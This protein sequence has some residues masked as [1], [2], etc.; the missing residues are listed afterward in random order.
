[1]IPKNVINK[2]DVLVA[3]TLMSVEGDK[4]NSTKFDALFELNGEKFRLAP[5]K[6][7][8]KAFEVAGSSLHVSLF[9]G[10]AESNRF[11]NSLGIRVVSKD[12]AIS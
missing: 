4:N 3:S 9:S 12:Y 2:N 5:K 7:I 8:A 6:L 10:G 11:L 1:M